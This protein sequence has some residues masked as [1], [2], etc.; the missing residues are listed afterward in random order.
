ML[1]RS[2]V[3]VRF[4][5]DFEDNIALRNVIERMP[6]NPSTISSSVN[7]LVNQIWYSD[8]ELESLKTIYVTNLIQAV[9]SFNGKTSKDGRAKY[10]LNR[11]LFDLKSHSFP[12]SYSF[13]N[14][15]KKEIQ[16]LY[17]TQA[18]N[19]LSSI[20]DTKS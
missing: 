19:H 10:D 20:E 9:A 12:I 1:F 14:S 2:E 6:T 3:L 13:L 15:F 18:D 8:D 16:T 4:G 5:M 17:L 11:L 7:Q